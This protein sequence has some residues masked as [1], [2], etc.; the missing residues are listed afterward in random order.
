[1]EQNI[2]KKKKKHYYNV[3]QPVHH[4]SKSKQFQICESLINPKLYSKSIVKSRIIQ[5]HNLWQSY[6]HSKAYLCNLD[7]GPIATNKNKTR[8]TNKHSFKMW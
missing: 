7:T 2:K 5:S 4:I 6:I 1:M 8:Q 3:I